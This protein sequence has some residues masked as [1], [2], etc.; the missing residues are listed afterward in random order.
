MLK[1]RKGLAVGILYAI[2]SI[3]SI[4]TFFIPI[5]TSSVGFTIYNFIANTIDLLISNFKVASLISGALMTFALLLLIFFFLGRI[6]SAIDK[7]KGETSPITYKNLLL[8]FLLL[9]IPVQNFAFFA[10]WASSSYTPDA[11]ILINSLGTFAFGGLL[12]IP[13]GLVIDKYIKGIRLEYSQ[14]ESTS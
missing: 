3:L 10:F 5:A 7:K 13:V 14:E 4:F 12:F 9:F 1:K 8:Y 6:K 2:I 11:Q